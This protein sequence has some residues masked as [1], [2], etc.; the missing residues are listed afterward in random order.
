MRVPG[1]VGPHAGLVSVRIDGDEEIHQTWDVWCSN[2]RLQTLLFRRIA[3]RG[4]SLTISALDGSLGQHA[5]VYTDRKLLKVAGLMAI[6]LDTNSRE[7][8]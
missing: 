3:P 7:Q 6:S 8:D 4:S 5:E 1:V 2:E